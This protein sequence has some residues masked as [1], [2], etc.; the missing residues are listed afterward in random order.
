[1]NIDTT[2]LGP[3]S[4]A[5]DLPTIT[6]KESQ[7]LLIER[8][9]AE[10]LARGGE[11]KS[12]G[13]RALIMATWMGSDKQ[14]RHLIPIGTVSKILNLM[15]EEANLVVLQDDFPP[16]Y[17]YKGEPHWPMPSVK[18]WSLNNR[19]VMTMARQSIGRSSSPSYQVK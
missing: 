3:I 10:F 6:C 2:Q 11:I 18:K 1:M 13:N 19:K 16:A 14:A 7:R 9:T 4:H 17:M 5:A 8:Q 12:S 15:L